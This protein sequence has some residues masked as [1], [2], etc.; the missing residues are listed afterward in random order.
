MLLSGVSKQGEKRH[1][2]WKCVTEIVLKSLETC[3]F[4]AHF[5]TDE[6]KNGL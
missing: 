3:I 5:S 4:A 6:N 1:N 2:L